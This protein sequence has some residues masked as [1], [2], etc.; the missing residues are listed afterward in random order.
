ME[1]DAG[2]E[3]F[4]REARTVAALH[5]PNIVEIYNIVAQAGVV[6]IVF[7]LVRGKSLDKI[8]LERGRFSLDWT[9]RFFQPVDRDRALEAGCSG[10]ITKPIRISRFPAQIDAYLLPEEGAA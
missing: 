1:D 3:A 2:R 8:L 6:Y 5:H 10:Y 4:L 9:K 7:E